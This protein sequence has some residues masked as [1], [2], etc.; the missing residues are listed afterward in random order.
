MTSF[1]YNKG[2][3]A[4]PPEVVISS[5][6]RE[7]VKS[8]KGIL[9]IHGKLLYH[10]SQGKLLNQQRAFCQSTGSRYINKGHFA[11]PREVII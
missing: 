4:N 9:P 3:F 6:P 11:N 10:Q 7:V 5:K 8:T 1:R 2:H